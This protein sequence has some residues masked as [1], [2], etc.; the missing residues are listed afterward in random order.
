M[1]HL[2][3]H[4]SNM[5]QQRR[6]RLQ[7]QNARCELQPRHRRR[8]FMRNIPQKPLLSMHKPAQLLRHPVDPHRQIAQLVPPIVRQ[9][10]VELSLRQLLSR[11]GQ[12]R[13]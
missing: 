1:S 3:L 11:L 7:F 2:L 12:S 9:R 5:R 13:H 6:I 8:Q 10:N 4:L